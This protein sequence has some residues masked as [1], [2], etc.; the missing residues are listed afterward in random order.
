MR[1]AVL[2]RGPCGHFDACGASFAGWYTTV[3]DVCAGLTAD[4]VVKLPKSDKLCPVCAAL[5]G[6]GVHGS[7]DI[8]DAFGALFELGQK[9]VTGFLQGWDGDTS[10]A[11]AEDATMFKIGRRLARELVEEE[12]GSSE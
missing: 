8:E 12:G 9:E 11:S 5:E 2:V 6:R 1:R 7:L 10:P 3:G 4:Q